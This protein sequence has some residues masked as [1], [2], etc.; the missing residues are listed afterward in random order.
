MRPE[1]LAA[2]GTALAVELSKTTSSNATSEPDL[3]VPPSSLGPSL[4]DPPTTPE[5]WRQINAVVGGRAVE[6]PDEYNSPNLSKCQ[7]GHFVCQ[8]THHEG[9]LSILFKKQ[10]K[11]IKDDEGLSVTK[12]NH[13]IKAVIDS[14]LMPQ[15]A[16]DH[17]CPTCKV[18]AQCAPIE[19]LTRKQKLDIL[20]KRESP[21]VTTNTQI[22]NDPTKPGFLKIVPRL[23][24]AGQGGLKDRASVIREFDKKM[25]RLSA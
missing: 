6:K 11:K 12:P 25:L 2:S 21:M 19:N 13:Q 20:L 8:S 7:H 15:R 4:A 9:V 14:I 3:V 5:T 17:R 10:N 1:A 23:P 16:N 18:C 24:S 22:V